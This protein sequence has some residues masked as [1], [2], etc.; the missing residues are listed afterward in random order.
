MAKLRLKAE[1]LDDLAVISAFVQDATVQ[2]GEIAFVPKTRQFAL[3]LHRFCWESGPG[4]TDVRFAD[5][6]AGRVSRAP[7][8]R[9][10]AGLSFASVLRVRRQGL[11]QQAAD[12]VLALLAVEAVPGEDGAAV[13]TLTFAGGA[14]LRLDVECI[15][16]R[17]EDLGD[18][19]P[20]RRRPA[21]AVR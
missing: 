9:V 2:V 20:V 14:Q 1:D 13:I 21:H 5:V 7:H 4:G 11:S 16:V 17:L 19:W 10:R 12:Q 3:M 15:D 18:P 6:V 8:E